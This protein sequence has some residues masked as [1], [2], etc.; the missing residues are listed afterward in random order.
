MSEPF[1]FDLDKM[2]AAVDSETISLPP[3]LTGEERR[4]FIKKRLAE[5]DAQTQKVKDV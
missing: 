3:G 5:I 1:N 2:K 4:A